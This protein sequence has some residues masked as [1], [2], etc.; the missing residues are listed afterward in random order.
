MK[1]NNNSENEHKY[2]AKLPDQSELLPL[3]GQEG[4]SVNYSRTLANTTSWI[5]CGYM[6]K[7]YNY[8]TH[9]RVCFPFY[10]LVV[11]VEGKGEFIDDKGNVFPLH[12]GS[13]FQRRPDEVHSSHVISGSGWREYYIDCNTELYQYLRS[14]NIINNSQPV[15]SIALNETLLNDIE[16][17]MTALSTASHQALPDVY[18]Q[19]QLL[20]RSLF[21]P[22]NT[23]EAH[24]L[25]EDNMVNTA[26]QHFEN[27]YNERFDLREYCQENGWGYDSFRKRFKAKMGLS[28]RE[29]LVRKRMEVACQLLRSSSKQISYI[30][31]ELGYASPYEFSNQFHKHYGVSP[32][33]FRDGL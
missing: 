13:V 22:E 11:V 2:I 18:L 3:C 7:S 21:D 17:L 9:E 24:H 25:S 12:S 23:Q 33:H 6:T 29:Y 16:K 1:T 20:L 10:S 5:G 14:M 8:L 31:I 32:K 4:S 19:Y 15:F 28:P 26:C 30:A 27:R